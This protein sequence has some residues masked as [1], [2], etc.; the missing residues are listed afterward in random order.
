M[1]LKGSTIKPTKTEVDITPPSSNCIFHAT[2][3][4]KTE[5]GNNNLSTVLTVSL[6]NLAHP[7]RK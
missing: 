3:R 7:L 6:G 5:Q 1:D 2:D 4:I